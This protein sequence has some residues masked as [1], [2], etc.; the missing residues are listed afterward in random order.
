M[1]YTVLTLQPSWG[2]VICPEIQF[3]SR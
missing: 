1:A 3:K 2:S